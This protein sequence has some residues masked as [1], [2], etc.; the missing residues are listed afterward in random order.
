MT[1]EELLIKKYEEKL[2]YLYAK[3]NTKSKK[4]RIMYDLFNFSSICY[5]HFGIEKVFAWDLDEELYNLVEDFLK[6][7]VDNTYKDKRDYF[8]ISN[9]VLD[10]FINVRYP[11]YDDYCKLLGH[12]S[13]YEL[14][15]LTFD[16]LN[17]YDPKLVDFYKSKLVNCEVFDVSLYAKTGFSGLHYSMDGLRKSIIFC[18]ETEGSI[19]SNGMLIHELGHAYENEL[20]Y[21]VGINGFGTMKDKT[22]YT[23]VS[24]RF[25]EYAFYNYL[26]ENRI[27]INDTRICLLKYYKTMLMHIYGINLISKSESV[28]INKYGYAVIDD[29]DISF[30]ANDIKE[31]LNY[32]NLASELEEEV[33]Y[34]Y[35]F[36][37]GLGALFAIYLYDNYK[38]DPSY[39][40]KEFKNALINYPQIGMDAFQRVG[41]TQEE[42]IKG[43]TLKR[44]LTDI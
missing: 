36:T 25:F 17:S 18:E 7:F 37:Y 41:V 39:F 21:G 22:P 15:E 1:R 40:R 13:P 26:K 16:F 11:F 28:F 9:S 42:L 43:T 32:Y 44:V 6:M 4:K 14:Q 10:T 38:K 20:M 31:K 19:F 30:Y 3:A 23:E 2:N 33:N 27:Y 5:E 35:S 8:D 12:V 24:S 29:I 34:K